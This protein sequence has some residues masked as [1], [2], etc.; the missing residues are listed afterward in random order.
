MLFY[1]FYCLDNDWIARET[2]LLNQSYKDVEESAE[3][4]RSKIP[5]N[6]RKVA[7]EKKKEG[8]KDSKKD[9][10]AKKKKGKDKG[11]TH[12]MFLIFLSLLLLLKCIG[13]DDELCD[14]CF[15]AN[16]KT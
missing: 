11:E 12:S 4:I 7:S 13:S 2:E 10:E 3:M 1:F 9:P 6:L 15:L 14:Q 16:Y 5:E 8:K